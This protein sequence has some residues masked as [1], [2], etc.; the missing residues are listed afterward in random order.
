[1]PNYFTSDDF[2]RERAIVAEGVAL[3]G[4]NVADV[5]T[6][7]NGPIICLGLFVHI[8]TAV[9]NNLALMHF[10]ADPTVGAA[11]TEISA[12][13]GGPDI[14]LAAI[15]DWFGGPDIALAAIGDWF[16]TDG[17]SLDVMIHHPNGT[18]L[19]MVT[20]NNGGIVIPV[21][22]IDLG[23]STANPTTGIADIFMRY[24]PLTSGAIV[25]L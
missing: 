13:A 5:F 19:P 20:N 17:D 24:K 22:G 11:A 4:G 15:G 8:T 21:G 23:L 2:F 3:T 14:A 1:M 9:S 7:E 18:S 16:G 6:V 10:E 12:S 25:T